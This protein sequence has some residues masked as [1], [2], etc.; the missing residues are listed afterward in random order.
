MALAD[1][2]EYVE[3]V[4]WRVSH[5]LG[6]VNEPAPEILDDIV[7]GAVLAF[8]RLAPRVVTDTLSGD[9]SAYDIALSGLS[10]S[11][12]DGFSVLRR[13]EYPADSSNRTQD[14]SWV[15][16]NDRMLYPDSEAPT[17]LRFL[18]TIP[19]SASDNIKLLYTVMHTVDDDTVT[20][21]AHQE[22]A[23]IDIGAAEVCKRYATQYGHS[24][25]PSIE[26]D[27]VDY[28]SKGDEWRRLAR[29]FLEDAYRK[30][31]LEL[32][33]ETG[34][35]TPPPA[36]TRIDYDPRSIFGEQVWRSSRRR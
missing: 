9:G 24:T 6:G 28:H 13:V 1:K 20:V 33:A 5:R 34:E 3:S 8:S 17:H 2:Q 31:G 36:G 22:G 11:W 27:A 4:K 10:P 30:L 26:A 32:D 16:P 14:P 21:P 23:L 19:A 12:A 7:D 29:M 18:A 15:D 35:G 25:D